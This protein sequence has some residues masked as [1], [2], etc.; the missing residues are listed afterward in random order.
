MNLL[1][2][3]LHAGVDALVQRTVGFGERAESRHLRISG[4]D[5]LLLEA[6]AELRYLTSTMLAALAWGTNNTRLRARLLDLFNA[7]LVR[8]FRPRLA[9]GAGDAQ[10][11]YELDNAGYR[12]LSD[13]TPSCPPWRRTE[14][15]AFSYAEH[16]LEL[17]ALLC[18]LAA[19]AASR[20]GT[21]GPL[22]HAAPFAIRGARSGRLDPVRDDRPDDADDSNALPEG[23]VVRP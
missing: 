9:Q 13:R 12:V 18:E 22:L 11:V 15:A 14:L 16:D 3:E 21:R 7:G 6:L 8:R 10:W 2:P 4:R 17:N 20:I 5:L 19:R 23:F 1:L